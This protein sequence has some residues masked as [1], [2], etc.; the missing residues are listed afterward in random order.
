M[1]QT[2][3]QKRKLEELGDKCKNCNESLVEK[4]VRDE[5]LLKKIRWEYD[6]DDNNVFYTRNTVIT[7][8]KNPDYADQEW[9]TKCHHN[10]VIAESEETLF[11]DLG[12]KGGSKERRVRIVD[13]D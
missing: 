12:V 13:C 2:R 10:W 8:S 4:I 3:K 9:C 1:V 7:R 5:K 11:H 6:L